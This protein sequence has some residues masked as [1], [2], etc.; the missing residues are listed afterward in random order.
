VT[1]MLKVAVTEPLVP[2]MVASPA[3]RALTSPLEL[4]FATVGAD[5]VQFSVEVTFC[6][7]PSL[8]V[9]VAVSC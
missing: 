9:A 2:V 3:A 4:T 5:E 6:V 7:L 1:L 8:N